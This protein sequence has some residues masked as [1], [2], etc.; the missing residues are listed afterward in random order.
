MT[1]YSLL[2]VLALALAGWDA[3]RRWC[4]TAR[5]NAQ[6]LEQIRLLNERADKADQKVQ[7]VHDRFQA[8]LVAQRSRNPLGAVR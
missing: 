7:A 3:F 1:I 2:A 6:A 8:S 5:F 4:A